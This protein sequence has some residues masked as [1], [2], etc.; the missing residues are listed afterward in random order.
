MDSMDP[1]EEETSSIPK[2][3][4]S[5]LPENT[6]NSTSS[7]GLEYLPSNDSCVMT[8]MDSNMDAYGEKK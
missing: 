5:T 1:H 2:V 8:Q 3:P 4:S 6:N 7:N